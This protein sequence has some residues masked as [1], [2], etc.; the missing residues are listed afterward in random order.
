M[1]A[2]LIAASDKQNEVSL[3]PDPES[4]HNRK[5]GASDEYNHQSVWHALGTMCVSRSALTSTAA[6][7]WAATSAEVSFNKATTSQS[8]A[9][10]GLLTGRKKW[11]GLQKPGNFST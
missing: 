4:F 7:S 3:V 5:I 2:Q 6:R 10:C 11:A 1:T 8:N 9:S